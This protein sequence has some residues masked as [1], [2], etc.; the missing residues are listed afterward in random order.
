MTKP[1]KI[2]TNAIK[3]TISFADKQTE[4]I[5]LK[6]GQEFADYNGNYD[7]PGSKF[8][9]DLD[10]R[11]IRYLAVRPERLVPIAEI[12]LI[13]GPDRTAPIIMAVTIE[14]P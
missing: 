6:N 7:V 9:F 1:N 10:G 4:E 8:A 12:E 14:S 11:Q 5:I 2:K 13:K 3:V